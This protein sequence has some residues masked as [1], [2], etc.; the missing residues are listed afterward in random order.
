MENLSGIAIQQKRGGGNDYEKVKFFPSETKQG[1]YVFDIPTVANSIGIATTELLNQLQHL[2]SMGEITYEMKDPA[3]CYFIIKNPVDFCSLATDITRWLYE[4]ETC[5]IR[6]LDAMY[7]AA[8]FAAKA[9]DK[10]DGCSDSLH[11]SCLQRKISDYFSRGDDVDCSDFSKKTG[12][13]RGR[14]SQLDFRVVME[15]ATSELMN[16]VGKGTI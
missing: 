13:N 4:A 11:T 6:K 12:I 2:K 3:F 9:C 16:F 5:K 15:A 8:L 14:Y 10:V 7:D 1:H